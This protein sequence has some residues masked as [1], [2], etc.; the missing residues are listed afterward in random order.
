MAAGLEERLED[1]TVET[2]F[3]SFLDHGT[4]GSWLGLLGQSL[5]V[6]L[7]EGIYAGESLH[8]WIRDQ[9]A[10]AG[11]RTFGDL[12]QPGATWRTPVE[13]RYRLV[14]IVS[15]VSRGRMLRLPWDCERLLGLRPGHAAGGGRRA[16][17]GVDPLLLPAVADPGRA[18]S[19]PTAG[20]SWS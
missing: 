3:A 17:L 18:A 20:A 4:L 13:Q 6:L 11:V 19:W 9:L 1:L 15:D 12:R 10:E 2:D 5:D 16:R 14:V 8:R 7:R